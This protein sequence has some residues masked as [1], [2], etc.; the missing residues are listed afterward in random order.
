MFHVFSV[1]FLPGKNYILIFLNVKSFSEMNI[2]VLQ[3]GAHLFLGFVP[4][5]HLVLEYILKQIKC[6]WSQHFAFFVLVLVCLRTSLSHGSLNYTADEGQDFI[7]FC[8]LWQRKWYIT[9]ERVIQR[10]ISHMRELYN[11]KYHTWE[12]VLRHTETAKIKT[13]RQMFHL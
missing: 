3:G 10:K 11:V 5:L 6:L 12:R 9:H 4:L 7:P 13:I 8:D 2:T 1:T